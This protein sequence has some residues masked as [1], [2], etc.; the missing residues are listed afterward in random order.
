M[1]LLS[2]LAERRGYLLPHAGRRLVG[3]DELCVC[4]CVC[5]C[6]CMWCV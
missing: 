4:V 1:G 6:V 5:V 3:V 2:D